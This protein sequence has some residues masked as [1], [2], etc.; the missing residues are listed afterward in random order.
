MK[1]VRREIAPC[2]YRRTFIL[3]NV[4]DREKIGA[5]LDN[6]LLTLVLPKSADTKPR[7]IEIS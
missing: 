5:R 7:K 4:I 1:A 2:L 3:G 6:G